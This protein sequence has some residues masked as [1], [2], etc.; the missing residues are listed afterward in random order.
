[1]DYIAKHWRGELSLSVAFW[2]NNWVLMLPLGIVLGL[3]SVWIQGWGQGLQAA[4]ITS[5][6]GWVL[7]LALSIWAPVGAWRSAT[8]YRDEG[9][10]PLLAAGAKL[11]LGLGLL[12]TA[13]SVVFD[14]LPEL[15]SQLRM[16]AGSDPIGRLDIRVAPDGRSVTLSGPFGAGAASR[17]ER[18][19]K[20][21]PQ[22][23]RV[24]LESPGGRLFEANEIAT[25]VRQRGL[26][27]R[28]EGDCASACTLVFIAGTHRSVARAAKLGFHRASVQS[29]NPLHDQLA[30]KKLAIL[31]DKAGLPR[32]FISRVL[33]T[34]SSHMWFPETD[35]LVA[36]GVLPKPTLLPELDI[37]LP[38][39][40]PL[41][42]YREVLDNN[43]LWVALDQRRAGAIDDASQRMLAARQRG[44]DVA[45]SALEGQAVA[46]AAVPAVVRSAGSSALDGFLAVLGS[47]LRERKATG[48]TE[49]QAV[50]ASS[51]GA[52][53]AEGAGPPPQRLADWLENALLEP[54]DLQPTRALTALEI[55]VLQREMGAD[56][57]GRITALTRGAGPRKVVPGC[58]KAI[59]L[60]DAVGRLKPP[61]RRLAA[62]LMLMPPT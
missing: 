12:Y 52:N 60:L 36:A 47:E 54:A 44:L 29:M 6:V 34:P 55:E 14:V 40:A 8:T 1:M 30:N 9:G 22:L 53:A 56:G 5:L 33:E 15:P 23:Q 26:Q 41:A 16:A 45:A 43:A 20:S 62:R 61:Q 4:A 31:Y 18:T 17:F 51:L 46:L 3:L 58:A 25:Q 19:L 7:L 27:T 28:A 35:V 32:Y 21:A 57:P 59:E 24:V 48:D 42:A 37:G 2:V 13:A 10:S 50:L 49:C 38:A 39:D 11:V